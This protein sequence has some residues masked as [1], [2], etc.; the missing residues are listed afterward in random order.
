VLVVGGE[1]ER[2]AWLWRGDIKQSMKN[3]SMGMYH[4][5]NTLSSLKHHLSTTRHK[6]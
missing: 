3:E 5:K 4:G 6:I 2:R 1:G